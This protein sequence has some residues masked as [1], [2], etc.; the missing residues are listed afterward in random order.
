MRA[1][2]E[3][4][5]IIILLISPDFVGSRYVSLGEFF[6]VIGLHRF[7]RVDI[8]PILCDHVDIA[9]LPIAPHQYVPQ[10]ENNDLKPLADWPNVNL[11]LAQIAS[12]L[13]QMIE[14]RSEQDKHP[15]TVRWPTEGL[16]ERSKRDLIFISYS[17]SDEKWLLRLKIVLSPLFNSNYL[18]IW[19][20]TK[21]IPGTIWRD[22]IEKALL[23][24]KVAVL[25]VSSNFLASSFISESELPFLLRAAKVDGTKI[26]WFPVSSSLV[27]R[28]DIAHYQAAM[29]PKLPMDLLPK[30]RQEKALVQTAEAIER[31]FLQ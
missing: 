31:A 22:E 18:T 4:A 16:D 3:S 12:T 24:A 28:T 15:A 25:V 5:N 17:R 27:E 1:E 7:G 20:D 8:L 29:S 14:L 26:I 23:R 10:D 19:D 11:P 21:I 13:R 30:A 2:L 9:T 6:R